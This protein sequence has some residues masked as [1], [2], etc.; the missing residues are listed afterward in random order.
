MG[1]MTFALKLSYIARGT[2]VPAILAL[3]GFSASIAPA[4]ATE[5]LKNGILNVFL[6]IPGLCMCLSGLLLVF[7]YRL[8]KTKVTELQAE[9]DARAAAPA[10]T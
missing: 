6:L 3:V 8:T 7:G 4:D 1:S 2:L 9:I 5:T 10:A